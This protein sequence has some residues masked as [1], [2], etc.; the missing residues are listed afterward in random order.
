M[1]LV[2]TRVLG[3][4]IEG[5]VVSDVIEEELARASNARPEAVV[6]DSPRAEERREDGDGFGDRDMQ[7]EAV[8]GL[9]EHHVVQ[10][11]KRPRAFV[12]R[13]DFVGCETAAQSMIQR[14]PGFVDERR[15]EREELECS[16]RVS[17]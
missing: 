4:G 13:V 10:P 7:R 11:P 6:R 12:P 17:P 5:H 16:R 8:R 14:R 2:G 3:K 1:E 9:G 15:I